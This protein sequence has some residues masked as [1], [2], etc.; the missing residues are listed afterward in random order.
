MGSWGGERFHRYRSF[1]VC[2]ERKDICSGAKAGQNKAANLEII[3]AVLPSGLD[4]LPAPNRIFIGGG[5]KELEKIIRSACKYLK[6]N[7]IIIINTVLIQNL[8]AALDTLQEIRMQTKVIQIQI[9]K[10]K[11][12]PW[13]QRFNA[14]N[15]VW[16]ISG[17]K[18]FS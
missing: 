11:E 6:K 18:E 17:K 3:H 10:S 1:S 9:S 16:I 4:N 14:Q 13:G 5:G 15:P 7:G 2:K 8:K 12:M